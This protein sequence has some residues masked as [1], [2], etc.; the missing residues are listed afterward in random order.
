[1]TEV[2]G[3]VVAGGAVRG[4]KLLGARPVLE[5]FFARPHRMRGVERVI[6][7]IRAAQ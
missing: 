7:A 3:L 5:R 2:Q 6:V 4:A 1:M